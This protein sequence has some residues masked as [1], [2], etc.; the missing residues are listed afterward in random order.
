[1]PNEPKASFI[2]KRMM[3]HFLYYRDKD[4]FK[5]FSLF[6]YST[7]IEKNLDMQQAHRAELSYKMAKHL[8]EQSICESDI[9]AKCINIFV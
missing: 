9:V 1:M 7:I 3:N 5:T 6:S 8:F 2:L 4:Y